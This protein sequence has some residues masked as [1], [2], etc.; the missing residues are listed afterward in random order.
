M[1][2][3]GGGGNGGVGCSIASEIHAAVQN[4]VQM[5]QEEWRKNKHLM[6]DSESLEDHDNAGVKENRNKP[7]NCFT[8]QDTA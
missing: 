1:S 8:V 6:M 7:F 3:L 4:V 5:V 2:Q